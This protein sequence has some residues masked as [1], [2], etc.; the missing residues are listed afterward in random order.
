MS[1]PLYWTPTAKDEFNNLLKIIETEGTRDAVLRFLDKTEEAIAIIT[2]SPRSFSS[3]EHNDR[4]RIAAIDENTFMI[5]QVAR[6]NLRLIY[7]WDN[8]KGK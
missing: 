2:E 3:F 5:F 1:L 4:F 7:F 8:R 6:V